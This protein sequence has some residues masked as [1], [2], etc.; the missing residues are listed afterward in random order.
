M[1]VDR[2]TVL[3][4]ES[5]EEEKSPVPLWGGEGGRMGEE[6]VLEGPGD[7]GGL[8]AGGE[9]VCEG[10]VDGVRERGWKRLRE[11]E[12]REVGNGTWGGSSDSLGGA[13]G[14]ISRLRDVG[15]RVGNGDV[16]FGD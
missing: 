4:V 9:E 8:G 12:E 13:R 6:G 10:S 7:D 1:A 14:W 16:V 3:G 5:S 15:R 2:D 11:G